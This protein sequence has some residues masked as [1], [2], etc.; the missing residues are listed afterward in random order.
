LL[1]QREKGRRG[2]MVGVDQALTDKEKRAC[3]RKIGEQTR[4]RKMEDRQ[5]ASCS[6]TEL[7]SPLPVFTPEGTIG[8]PSV[9]PSVRQSVSQSV[10]QSVC[11][12]KIWILS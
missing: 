5:Q 1:A 9:R 10:R 3:Q 12:L 4:R 8:L 7:I 2:S 11:P 6:T